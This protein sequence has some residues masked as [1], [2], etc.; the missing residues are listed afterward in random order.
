[1]SLADCGYQ[2]VLSVRVDQNSILRIEGD[3]MPWRFVAKGCRVLSEDSQLPQPSVQWHTQ[4]GSASLARSYGN[5]FNKA[6][7]LFGI[8]CPEDRLYQHQSQHSILPIL[9]KFHFFLPFL[10]LLVLLVSFVWGEYF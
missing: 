2:T 1:M 4:I 9:A 7:S 10:P 3:S 8:E 5:C 6:F